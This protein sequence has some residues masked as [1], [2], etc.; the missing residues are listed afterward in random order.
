VAAGKELHSIEVKSLTDHLSLAFSPDS[1]TLAC[2]GAWDDS[3]FLRGRGISSIQGIE[4]TPKEGF[5]VLLWD[6]A[7]GKELRRCAGLMDK[8]KSVAF[9]PD[10]KTLAAAS[11]DGRIGLWQVATGKEVLCIMAHPNHVE[12]NHGFPPSPCVAFAP[13][14]KTLASA[15]MDRTIRLWDVSTAK[16]V[17]RFQSADG[18]FYTVAFSP[19]GRNLIAGS[20]DT[21]VT[22]WDV[23]AAPQLLKPAKPSYILIGD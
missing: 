21:T 15:S 7:T 6:T 22:I 1:K 10:G 8:I 16:E 12:P 4:V 20:S 11:G 3:S 23:A 18:G 9:S 14:G 5:L 13:D 19:D 17:G 2:G